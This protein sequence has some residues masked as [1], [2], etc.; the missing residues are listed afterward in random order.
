MM[1]HGVMDNSGNQGF[2][3]DPNGFTMAAGMGVPQPAYGMSNGWGGLNGP[4]AGIQPVGGEG[5]LRA[6][7]NMGPMDAMDLSSWDSGNPH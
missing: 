3:G 6:L 4:A 5:V 2:Y 7:M 1:N